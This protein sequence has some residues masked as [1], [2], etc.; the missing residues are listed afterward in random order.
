MK[1]LLFIFIALSQSAMAQTNHSLDDVGWLC[2]T[3]ERLDV[4][5]GKTGKEIWTCGQDELVGQGIT[6]SGT[7]TVF[8]EKIKIIASEGNLFYVAD[9]PEN[10]APV[11]FKFTDLS[12]AAFTCEND[13]HDFPKK[14]T[15]R[16][17][18]DI[19]LA[20]ISGNGKSITYRFAR[21]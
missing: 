12:A 15:Y 8:I 11:R 6:L 2:G 17:D 18:G 20:T 4:K 7:D 9:V 16:K 10:K 5:P 21:K 3:W 14:I 1:T 19:L 13:A